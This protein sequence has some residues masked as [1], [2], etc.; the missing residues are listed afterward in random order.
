MVREDLDR[1]AVKSHDVAHTLGRK[2][3]R[4]QSHGNLQ[5]VEVEVDGPGQ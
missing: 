5:S 3:V 4:T 1:R 2:R